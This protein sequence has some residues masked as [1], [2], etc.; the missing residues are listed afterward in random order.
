MT[1]LT[2]TRRPPQGGGQHHRPALPCGL[3]DTESTPTPNWQH[4]SWDAREFLRASRLAALQSNVESLF[5]VKPPKRLLLKLL[6]FGTFRQ[7]LTA[8]NLSYLPKL[9]QDSR[10]QL[11]QHF[12]TLIES[13]IDEN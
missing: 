6:P 3:S 1:T 7:A 12:L 11:A 10:H 13:Q 9:P 4:W 8:L 2:T 5:G